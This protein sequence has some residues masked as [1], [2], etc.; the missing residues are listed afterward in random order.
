MRANEIVSRRVG[1][2]DVDAEPERDRKHEVGT[3]KAHLRDWVIDHV[4]RICDAAKV[5]PVTAHAMRG[6]LA[7]LTAA[8]ARRPLDCGDPRSRE[9][10]HHDARVRGAGCGN[11]RRGLVLLEGPCGHQTETAHISASR[12]VFPVEPRGIEPLTSRVR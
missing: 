1:D 4:H 3:R 9:Q 7:T 8:R 2:L 5:P 6:L 10:A 11:C 12:L